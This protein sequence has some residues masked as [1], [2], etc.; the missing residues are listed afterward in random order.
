MM[1]ILTPVSSLD[2][3]TQN[4]GPGG[5]DFLCELYTREKFT[6]NHYCEARVARIQIPVKLDAKVAE[7]QYGILG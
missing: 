6:N 1:K 5:A 2:L 3:L 7:Y 4:L